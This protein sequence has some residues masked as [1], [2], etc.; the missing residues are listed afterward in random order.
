MDNEYSELM[1]DII[2]LA[3]ELDKY[4]KEASSEFNT[5][6]AAMMIL[7]MAGGRE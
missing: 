7:T 1:R 3:T 5:L 6:M 4:G 2:M